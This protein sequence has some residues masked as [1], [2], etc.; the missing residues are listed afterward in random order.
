MGI[1]L[2]VQ[3]LAKIDEAIARDH[4]SKFRRLEGQVL[5]HIGDAYQEDDGNHRSHLGA[6]V[7]GGKCQRAIWYG[8]RWASKKLPRG[9]KGEP[10]L[11]AASRMMRLWNRG[12]L[13]EGRFIAMLLMIDVQVY[14]QDAN[15]KQFRIG[16]FGGHFSG[17]GDG[18]LYNVPDLPAGVPCL[19]E[20]KTHSDKSFAELLDKGVRIAKPE[21]YV[22]MNEYMHHFGLLYCLYMAVNKNTEEL[23]AEIVMYDRVCAEKY[24]DVAKD[25]V[26][27]M[28]A[29]KRIAGG[30][31]GFFQCKHMCDETAVCYEAIKPDVNCRTC[32]HC[33]AM[34]DGTW[35]CAPQAKTLDKAAQL[36][37]CSNYR[38]NKGM[39]E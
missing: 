14:Q 12:H 17:S 30:N 21:H 27:R 39:N 37:G 19:G 34:P 2:A 20:F 32:M 15:G 25:L 18:I 9:K 11:K 38:L 5:P 10:K 1:W 36:A 28:N 16:A 4:G 8:F 6:S 3:T 23:H 31:P 13:E 35:Q 22:Q 7:I 24:L 33:F 26:F 29:P